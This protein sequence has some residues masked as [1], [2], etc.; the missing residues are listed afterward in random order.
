MR[1]ATRSLWFLITWSWLPSSVHSLSHTRRACTQ[2]SR[3]R[4]FAGIWSMS[5]GANVGSGITGPGSPCPTSTSHAR[6]W[7]NHL[8]WRV[9]S[10]RA[11]V[12]A[13]SSQEI[14]SSDLHLSTSPRTFSSTDST[15]PAPDTSSL[16]KGHLDEPEA[17]SSLMH[18][19][20]K[21]WEHGSFLV[22]D[23]KFSRQIRHIPSISFA[24]GSSVGSTSFARQRAILVARCETCRSAIAQIRW[25]F[26]SGCRNLRSLLI[27]SM[28]CSL[29]ASPTC[30]ARRADTPRRE[31]S[32]KLIAWNR[33]RTYWVEAR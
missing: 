25:P 22:S 4:A 28:N 23:E 18:S 21:R 6:A 9:R 16:H 8:F 32:T 7:Q 1:L 19:V 17:R 24:S 3:V 26:L 11:G 30:L 33:H 20:W 2:S 12:G 31:M 5:T 29:R 10:K 15:E 27:I 13:S 14:A